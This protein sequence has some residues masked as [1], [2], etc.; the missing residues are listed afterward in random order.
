MPRA[1]VAIDKKFRNLRSELHELIFEGGTSHELTPW[2]TRRSAGIRPL[3]SEVRNLATQLT[4]P[5]ESVVTS[6]VH[7]SVNR[8]CIA[9]N[10][11]QERVIYELLA[12]LF[13]SRLARRQ[14]GTHV[15]LGAGRA[16]A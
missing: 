9:E 14:A 4:V 1:R 2:L 5:F 3:L 16:S 10:S 12:R 6:C 8:L 11:S 13:A 7:M 15:H